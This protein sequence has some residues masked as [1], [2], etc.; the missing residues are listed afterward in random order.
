MVVQRRHRVPWRRRSTSTASSRRCSGPS[1]VTSRP[2]ARRALTGPNTSIRNRSPPLITTC[3]A[4]PRTARVARRNSNPGPP[5]CHE[6]PAL[7]SP[8]WA[9]IVI[10]FFLLVLLTSREWR[11]GRLPFPGRRGRAE[12]P[13]DGKGEQLAHD[14]KA[15]CHRRSSG[16]RGR[17]SGVGLI[18]APGASLPGST[19][20]GNDGNFVPNGGTPTGRRTEPGRTS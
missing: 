20:E 15:A 14:Q 17:G 7:C 12:L 10:V 8:A 3:A 5:A 2:S 18:A 9:S 1:G 6:G 13:L 4:A 16:L 19:F 11:P